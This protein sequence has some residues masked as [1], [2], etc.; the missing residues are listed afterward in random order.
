MQ[1]KDEKYFIYNHLSFTVKFHKDELT[2]SARIVG[3]EVIPFRWVLL[4]QVVC[5]LLG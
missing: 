2:D 4:F 3:F 5:S 1:S